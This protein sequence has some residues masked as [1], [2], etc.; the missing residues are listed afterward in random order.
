VLLLILL[1]SAASLLLAVWSFSVAL[2]DRGTNADRLDAIEDRLGDIAADTDAARR[3]I[4]RRA[5][6]RARQE[7]A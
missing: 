1:L 5:R 4:D 3:D 7:A 6:R 2:L